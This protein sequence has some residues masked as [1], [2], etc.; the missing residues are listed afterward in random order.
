MAIQALASVTYQINSLATTVLKL[1]D[2]QVMQIKDM[3][4]SVNLLSVAVA[5]HKE[6]VAR[7]EIGP[8]TT[9][10]TRIHTKIM[11]QPKSGQEPQRS[12][13]R[14]PIS[15]SILDSIGHCFE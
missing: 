7:R 4:S 3:E 6:K 11:T 9:P 8:F 10:K 1:L 5:I 2:S 14:V 12:Y 15:Y 13:S